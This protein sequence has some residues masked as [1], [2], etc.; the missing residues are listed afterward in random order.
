[1]PL[2]ILIFPFDILA[3]P[4]LLWVSLNFFLGSEAQPY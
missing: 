3:K 4:K 2:Y 1:M